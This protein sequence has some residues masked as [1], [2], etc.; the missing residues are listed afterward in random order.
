VPVSKSRKNSL[1]NFLLT[2]RDFRQLNFALLFN[3]LLTFMKRKYSLP[4]SQQSVNGNFVVETSLIHIPTPLIFTSLFKF[5]F[6]SKPNSTEKITSW[7]ALSLSANQGI[8]RLLWNPDIH[9]HL[10]NSLASARLQNITTVFKYR[11]C[12]STV[13]MVTR[14]GLDGPAIEYQWGRDFSYPSKPA[15][16][17]TQLKVT[18]AWRWPPTPI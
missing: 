15:L 10:H 1:C 4:S 14:Y 7:E 9:G 13:G 12:P 3:K 11:L 6:V 5:I 2:T 16:R 8:S 18:G 17:S